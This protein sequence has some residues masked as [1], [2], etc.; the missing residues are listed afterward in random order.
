MRNCGDSR[1]G[2]PG[3]A[4]SRNRNAAIESVKETPPQA[5]ARRGCDVPQALSPNATYILERPG[6]KQVSADKSVCGTC[7]AGVSACPPRAF[8]EVRGAKPHPDRPKLLS[9]LG[10]KQQSRR[11]RGKM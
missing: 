2:S 9:H 5:K 6:G 4:R 1:T 8:M 7:G 10:A 11:L 3:I